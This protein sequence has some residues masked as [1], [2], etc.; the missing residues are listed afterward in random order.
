MKPSLNA[1]GAGQ[2]FGRFRATLSVGRTR[3]AL[4]RL[5][6]HLLDDI[7]LTYRDAHAESRRPAWDVPANWLR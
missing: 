4:E 6:P 1:H 3:K 2:I 5:D 7:G